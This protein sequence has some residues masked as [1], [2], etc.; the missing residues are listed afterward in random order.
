[1]RPANY[2]K[3][4]I[5]FMTAAALVGVVGLAALLVTASVLESLGDAA[6]ALATRYVALGT[7]ILLAVDLLCLTLAVGYLLAT[8]LASD[9]SDGD[10]APDD[11]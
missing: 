11:E 2:W 5:A 7:G 6:G 3:T 1:M 10:Q 9:A 8:S 4:A